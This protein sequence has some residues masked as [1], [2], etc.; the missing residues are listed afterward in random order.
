MRPPS[1]EPALA[2]AADFTAC[3]A[4]LRDGS[5]TFYAASF[6]LPRRVREPA[7]ALYAF[8]RIADDAVDVAGGGTSALGELHA[9]LDR[10]Y[11]GGALPPGI[12]RAF[13]DVVARFD[14]PR[15]LP[16]ALLEG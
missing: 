11:A 7:C 4:L 9:R 1:P 5:R 15:V 2:T 6:L 10:I 12:E 3:C 8:C 16:D 13:A 14:L